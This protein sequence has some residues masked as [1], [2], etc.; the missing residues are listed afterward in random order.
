[1]ILFRRANEGDAEATVNAQGIGGEAQKKYARKTGKKIQN[2]IA[3]QSA[4]AKRK[5]GDLEQFY[6][7][8]FDLRPDADEVKFLKSVENKMVGRGGAIASQEGRDFAHLASL[9]KPTNVV[10]R[11]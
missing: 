1:M 11:T 2:E 3:G 5:Y 8:S 6:I 7:G 4:R 9:M 10:F